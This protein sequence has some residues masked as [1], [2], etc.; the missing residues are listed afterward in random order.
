MTCQI[1][2]YS[3][4]L[5]TYS[6]G[7]L[8]RPQNLKKKIF[9]VLLTRAS[10]S[11]RATA[12]LSKSQRRFFKTNVV[13]S[14]YTNFTHTIYMR[15]NYLEPSSIWIR[16]K[17]KKTLLLEHRFAVRDFYFGLYFLGTCQ[18]VN[19]SNVYFRICDY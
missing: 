19:L 3:K 1:R 13:K 17:K 14:Y 16:K 9:V 18:A 5:H 10:C 12:H 8:R 11:V 4:N 6:L 2:T 15:Q 7:F